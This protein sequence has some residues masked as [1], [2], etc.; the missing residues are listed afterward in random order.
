MLCVKNKLLKF[1]TL[2]ALEKQETVNKSRLISPM[3]AALI[4]L[5]KKTSSLVHRQALLLTIDRYK[6]ELFA[7]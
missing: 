6:H 4:P 5:N 1:R 3:R 2:F 7:Y